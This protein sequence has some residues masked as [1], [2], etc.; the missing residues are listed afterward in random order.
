MT[1]ANDRMEAIP[2]SVDC[3]HCG[4]LIQNDDVWTF[5]RHRASDRGIAAVHV[6][7]TAHG[8]RRWC[9][10]NRPHGDPLEAARREGWRFTR[11]AGDSH[12]VGREGHTVRFR[13]TDAREGRLRFGPDPTDS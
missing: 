12:P 6:A 1:T 10:A 2:E 7:C 3:L 11:E 8:V 13:L 9:R 4:R 5:T